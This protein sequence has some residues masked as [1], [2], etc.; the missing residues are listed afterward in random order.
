MSRAEGRDT[1]TGSRAPAV[2]AGPWAA[3]AAMTA[4]P[5]SPGPLVAHGSAAQDRSRVLMRRRAC[6][7]SF[8][9]RPPRM[10]GSREPVPKRRSGD[11]QSVRAF[12]SV[13]AKA[14][15]P[16]SQEHAQI[17][18]VPTVSPGRKVLAPCV[19]MVSTVP[20]APSRRMR[21]GGRGPERQVG[22][23]HGQSRPSR[24]GRA[25]ALL[26]PDRR[27]TATQARQARVR[28]RGHRRSQPVPAVRCADRRTGPCRHAEGRPVSTC[29]HAGTLAPRR[30]AIALAP[31]RT[32]ST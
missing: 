20:E 10:C 31:S 1:T 23:P 32:N 14:R 8:A 24:P 6:V 16:W 3:H 13:L 18:L 19:A 7:T 28:P 30:R 26:A 17:P 27:P 5:G 29:A 9:R 12:M 22:E 11:G 25:G 21:T 4:G 2:S 15:R